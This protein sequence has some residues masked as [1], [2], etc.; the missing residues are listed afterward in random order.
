MAENIE[1]DLA[2]YWDHIRKRNDDDSFLLVADWIREM[3]KGVGRSRLERVK[4]RRRI[5]WFALAIL[6]VFLI[7]S[8]TIPINRVERSGSLVNFSIQKEDSSLQKLSSLQQQLAFTSYEFLKPGQ[9]AI[10]FFILF[11]PGSEQ[12][13][14][15]LITGR[16]KKLN[17]V[18]KLEIDPINYTIRESLFS[19]FWH[20]TLK[21]GEQQKLKGEELSRKIKATLE[22]KG[23]GFLSIN[24]SNDKNGNVVFNSAQPDTDS[25][26]TTGKP[27]EKQKIQNDKA[28]NIPAGVG[29]LQIFD[30]LPGSWKVKY[31]PQK[32]YH[33]WIRL[34]D[35]SLMCFIVRYPE[36]GLIKIGDDGPDI[37]VGFSIRYSN[38]YSAILSLRGI[39][40]KFLSA[41]DKEI[42]F[43][44]EVTPKSANVRWKLDNEKKSWQS[45]ISGESNLEVVN[46][47][48]EESTDLENIIKDFIAKNPGVIKRP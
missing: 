24:I 8:C 12:K 40:W 35:S 25:L 14:L 4:R 39:E 41:N 2:A 45:A 29:K 31:T 38:I 47:V 15:E 13:K 10:A 5:R 16:L 43:K 21:L 34:N 22:D 11:I 27:G 33:H 48:R 42:N 1:N 23:L 28:E 46:L 9:P 19:T 32:T 30:W 18:Q 26:T 44:N 17:G 7:L 36:E 6:P 37:S 3:H 20:K